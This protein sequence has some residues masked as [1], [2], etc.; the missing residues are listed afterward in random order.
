MI[1][2]E[3]K[4]FSEKVIRATTNGWRLSYLNTKEICFH[5]IIA[6]IS[7]ET[8]S[9]HIGYVATIYRGQS[10]HDCTVNDKIR[11]AF[12]INGLAKIRFEFSLAYY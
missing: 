9:V 3:E 2:V 4:Q 12:V 1:V 10:F 7:V 11:R 5:K 6:Y 8:G